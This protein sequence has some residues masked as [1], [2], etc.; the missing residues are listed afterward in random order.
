VLFLGFVFTPLPIFV[1]WSLPDLTTQ[2][3]ATQL[4]VDVAAQISLSAGFQFA[5]R[6]DALATR[7][8][9]ESCADWE[10]QQLQVGSEVKI[11]YEFSV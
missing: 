5:L 6:G 7:E 9:H 3:N 1:I 11:A 4:A 8:R 2:T 10:Q